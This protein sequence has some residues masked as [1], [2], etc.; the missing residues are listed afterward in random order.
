MRKK[1]FLLFFTGILMTATACHSK[2]YSMSI[3]KQDFFEEGAAPASQSDTSPTTDTNTVLPA[4]TSSAPDD[5]HTITVNS[6]EQVSVTPD[7][8]QIVYAVHTQKNSAADCQQANTADVNQVIELLESL[9]IQKTSIKT[10]DYSMHPVYNY[11]GNTAKVVGY[12]A[13]ATLTVSDLPIENLDSI[14][15]ESI[16]SGINTVQS[17]TYMASEYDKSYQDALSKAVDAARQ[18]AAVLA[19]VTGASVGNAIS[20]Q[21]TSG[22]SEARYT[23]YAR[24]NLVNSAKYAKEESLSDSATSLMP[25]EISVEASIIIEYQLIYS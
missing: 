23:D 15:A 8:A 17:I 4:Y 16:L 11:S 10:S 24:S 25:G 14:L 5:R 13:T 22:Y 7:I 12:E 3:Q 6:S 1:L 21:E 2:E 18:K 20:I 19:S 9:G